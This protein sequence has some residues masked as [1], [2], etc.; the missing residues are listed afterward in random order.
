MGKPTGFLEFTRELPA[1]RLVENRINDYNEFVE[2]FSNDKL[3]NQAARCMDCGVPFCHNGCPLGNLIPDFND[4]VYRQNWLLAYQILSST[5][6]FPEFTGRIC[7]APCEGA[8]VLGI[9]QPPITIEEIE[10]HI[11]EIAFEKGYVKPYKPFLRS[12]KK[13]A[14][15]GSG[16]AG[17]ATAAQLNYAGHLVTVF[18]RDDAPGG[19]LRYGIPDFKLEKWVV[20]RR[21]DLLEQE[22][23]EFRCNIEVGNNYSVY[24]LI[25]EFHAVVLAGGSTIPRNLDIPGRDLKGVHFAMDYL[26]QQNKRINNRGL[27]G[28]DIWATGKD[29]VI[30]GGGDTGSD[31][32]GTANRQ[33]AKSVT[34]LELLPQPPEE[35]TVHMPWPTFPM[36][37]KVTS[38]HQEGANRHWAIATKKFLGDEEGNLRAIQLVDLEWKM[39]EDGKYAQFFETPGSDREIPCQLA[40][41]AMGFLY[42]QKEGLL[43]E[44]AVDLDERGN[45]K[46]TE[47]SYQTNIAKIFSAGDMRRGQSLVVWAIQEGRECAQKV[48]EYLI[49][50]SGRS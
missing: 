36:T 29:V 33:R 44:V 49:H 16:P 50:N 37:L 28:K 22:G 9:N 1:K 42:P 20:D 25:K 43:S 32:V 13:V 40:F 11:I 26:K 24:D 39:A 31:C 7:P 34:Q 17:L 2:R 12:G 15:I 48:D 19:L 6:N 4:A 41:L 47:H 3:N 23:I 10:K 45:V 46:A 8:C 21:I 38:S 18:E 27:D 14:V 30:I 5:N 35:R